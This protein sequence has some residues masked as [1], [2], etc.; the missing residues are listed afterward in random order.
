MFSWLKKHFIPHEGNE[1]RPHIL[2]D[3]TTRVIL[4]IIIFLEIFSFVIPVLLNLNM[5]GGVA[6]VLPAVLA[7]LTN[8]E[9]KTE[10]IPI[11]SVSP[12]LNKA[13]EMKAED[14]ATK[15][16]FAH[17]SPE[18]KTPWYWIEKV[19][20]K[21]QYAG[22]NLAINFT[23]SKDVANAW[24]NSP[25]HKANIVK[26]NYTEMG[27]G[28]AFGVYQGHNT[29]FVAQVYA[30][31][32]STTDQ[33]KLSKK[34]VKVKTAEK[35]VV[36][37]TKEKINVLGAEVTKNTENKSNIYLPVELPK[38]T[39]WQRLIASPRNTT[40][41]ILFSVFGIIFVALFLYIIMKTKNHHKDIVTNSL[42]MLSLVLAFFVANN[43]WAKNN[44]VT[45]DSLDY[46]SGYIAE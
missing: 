32:L 22:E 38:P 4:V 40:N 14:M 44:L 34:E 9:R 7:D 25:S 13:A 2:R 8:N 43:F 24:L 35:S 15:G 45:L 12:I 23:D 41:V 17:T 6:A 20:Y 10:N 3:S 31:P 29:I 46:S 1:H 21:Y 27:T 5:K 16:Y 30:N 33:S 36:V 28:I 19:G 39:F 18:G 26:E 42:L 11:L 37:A